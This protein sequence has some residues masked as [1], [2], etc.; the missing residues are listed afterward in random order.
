MIVIEGDYNCGNFEDIVSKW[1]F[2][3]FKVVVFNFEKLWES[4]GGY[5]KRRD[6]GFC[7]NEFLI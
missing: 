4:F 6:L 1:N 7:Y 2:I 5:I 3:F